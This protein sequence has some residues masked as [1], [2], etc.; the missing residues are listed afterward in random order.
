MTRN[1]RKTLYSARLDPQKLGLRLLAFVEITLN[2]QSREAMDLFEAHVLKYDD[3]LE[4][5]LMSGHADYLFRVAVTDLDQFD[6]IHRFCLSLLPGVSS[7][8]T[9][10]AIR[11]IKDFAGFVVPRGCT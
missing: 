6:Y 11:S 8:R 1:N 7:M 9:S 3:V 4:C 10:F 2:S 5:H